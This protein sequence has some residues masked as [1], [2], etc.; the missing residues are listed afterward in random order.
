[1]T[2]RGV[3]VDADLGVPRV[4]PIPL[5]DETQW[6]HYLTKK[7]RDMIKNVKQLQE[8]DVGRLY[9]EQAGVQGKKLS[10]N[11]FL[12]KFAKIP[13]RNSWADSRCLCSGFLETL[14]LGELYGGE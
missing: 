9:L 10:K 11:A 7:G 8:S 12:G 5:W 6:D 4:F 14:G 13:V 2:K 1:M 3:N